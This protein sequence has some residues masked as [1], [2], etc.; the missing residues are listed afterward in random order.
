MSYQR[1]FGLP[2]LTPVVK[3]LIIINV[4]FF[5][6]TIAFRTINVY[7]REEL[8]LWYLSS[9]NFGVW[10][11]LTHMFMH[12]DE[13]HLFGNMLTLFFFGT[14]IERFTAWGSPRFLFFYFSCGLGGAFAQ[15]AAQAFEVYSITGTVLPEVEVAYVMLGASGAVYG[16]LAAV[17][18]LF[19]NKV[20][21]LI[22]PPIPLKVKW[23]VLGLIVFDIFGGLN[24]I[25]TNTGHFAHLGGAL[26]G[27]LMVYYWSRRGQNFIR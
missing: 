14:M 11:F 13:R 8:S 3:N 1:S 16:V 2:R 21:H 18:Y 12:A 4:L 26:V 20:F 7:L 9:E 10:Q 17:A 5:L 15:M 25:S 27:F 22:I 19:P 23:L 6:A 24:L